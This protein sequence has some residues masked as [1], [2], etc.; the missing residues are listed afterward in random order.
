MKNVADK[1]QVGCRHRRRMFYSCAC[2]ASAVFV[3]IAFERLSRGVS[4]TMLCQA[5]TVVLEEEN[6]KLQ[7]ARQM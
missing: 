3:L 1:L 5:A 2:R 4:L 7:D 6:F